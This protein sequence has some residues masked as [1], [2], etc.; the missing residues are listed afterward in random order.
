MKNLQFNKN[1][2]MFFF[3]A[4]AFFLS[5]E[6]VSA[7][8]NIGISPASVDFKDVLRGGYAERTVVISA[9]SIEPVSVGVSTW[10]NVSDWINVSETSFEVSKDKPYYLNVF[11]NPP[12]DIPNGKYTSFVRVMTSYLG[13]GIEGHAVGVVRSSLDLAINIEIVD[14]EI[15]QC[16]ASGFGVQ[17]VEIGDDVLFSMKVFNNGNIRLNPRV[18]INIWDQDQLSIVKSIDSVQKEILP[19]REEDLLVRVDSS[20][21][22]V[23]Q[24]WAEISAI[25]CYSSSLLTFDILEKGALKANGE[26]LRILTRATANKGE[27]VPIEVSFK[28]IGEKEVSAQF[29]GQISKGGKLIQVLESQIS[30]VLVGSI[31]KFNFYF[32]PQDQGKYIVSG[33]VFYEGKKTFEKSTVLDVLQG[34]DGFSYLLLIIY[35]GLVILIIFLFYKIRKER[36]LYFKRLGRIK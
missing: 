26:L 16:S 1:F 24:Y 2:R 6:Y 34:K 5:L 15:I 36:K 22:R 33:R 4:L 20:Q 27:I 23:G 35:I 7:V 3:L 17:S 12:K 19:T 21:L 9:S 28:N 31:E 29:R 11:V 10:G 13:Q 25:D 8:V 32:T 18:T 14:T 30:D